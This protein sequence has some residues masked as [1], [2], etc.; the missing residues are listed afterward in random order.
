MSSSN[1]KGLTD[2]DEKYTEVED[3]IKCEEENLEVL[4]SQ[5]AEI[6]RISGNRLSEKDNILNEKEKDN[7]LNEKARNLYAAKVGICIFVFMISLLSTFFFLP[8]IPNMVSKSD[9]GML[10][11]VVG[12][13]AGI[14]TAIIFVVDDNL[15][16]QRLIERT[17]AKRFEIK[18]KRSKLLSLMQQ[19]AAEDENANKSRTN[20]DYGSTGENNITDSAHPNDVYPLYRK[21]LA[22]D[23]LGKYDEAIEC[24]DKALAI[25]PNYE[26]ALNNKKI[27]R[28]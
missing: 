15:K 23:K 4:T 5:Y 22:V 2:C 21:G 9:I 7:R 13:S 12:I 10:S 14:I 18:M 25:D 26:P 27:R 11:V 28:R 16:T 6:K 24:Y 3:R 1:V 8:M 20:T 19:D 17:V